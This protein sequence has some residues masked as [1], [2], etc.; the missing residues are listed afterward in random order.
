MGISFDWKKQHEEHIKWYVEKVCPDIREH[1][2][3]LI[4][5]YGTEKPYFT[6]AD[7]IEKYV[8]VVSR[9]P[10]GITFHMGEER[11]MA[12]EILAEKIEAGMEKVLEEEFGAK[13]LEP[14]KRKPL[15]EME[16]LYGACDMLK[17]I[18]RGR[19]GSRAQEKRVRMLRMWLWLWVHPED[20]LKR[21]IIS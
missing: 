1:M 9:E 7:V 19:T 8:E 17:Q 15:P 2:P 5:E 13:K 18:R 20:R 3:E 12:A 6:T 4:M 16:I 21:F 11:R 14:I 10:R